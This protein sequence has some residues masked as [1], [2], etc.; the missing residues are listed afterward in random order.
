MPGE[1]KLTLCGIT[2]QID[3]DMWDWTD[4]EKKA[5]A[6]GTADAIGQVM[7]ARLDATQMQ[8]TDFYII[9]HDKD[10]R[11]AWDEVTQV[12]VLG[13]ESAVEEGDTVVEGQVLITG[14]IHMEGA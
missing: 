14:N 8:V 2:Q 13:G 12:E 9:L 1:Q 4:E 11:K 7:L 5:L 10:T 3:P 6:V